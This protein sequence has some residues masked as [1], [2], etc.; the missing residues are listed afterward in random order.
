MANNYCEMVISMDLKADC[1]NRIS[2]GV[3]HR[4]VIMN[5]DDIDFDLL[6]RNSSRPNVIESLIMKSGKRG[7]EVVIPS[8][9]AF[10]GT[11]TTLAEG[12]INTFTNTVGMIILANDP[13]VTGEIMDGL[14][15]GSFVV[16]IENK[17]KNTNKVTNPGDGV[18][19]IYGLH[20]G[21][22]ATTLENDKYSDDTL[23]GWNV[24]LTEDGAPSSGVF[25]F[26]TNLKTT[27]TI[28]ESLTVSITGD[29]Y[30]TPNALTVSAEG[31]TESVIIAIV[32]AWSSQVLSSATW[33]T[34]SPTTGAAGTGPVSI[35]VAANTTGATRVG[36]IRF[37]LTADSTSY[38]D[39]TITQPG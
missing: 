10:S 12:V 29:I 20:T 8:T 11:G 31:G 1:D 22:R 33:I 2:K 27:R 37:F 39:V 4:G 18:F 36:V 32:S 34:L 5:R 13:D 3:E 6:T 16:I 9:T 38:K 25:L 24:V 7:F 30:V 28:F 15:N 21:L 19:Q 23:G 35:T 26:K 17:F 14:A